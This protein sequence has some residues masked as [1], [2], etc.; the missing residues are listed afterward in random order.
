MNNNTVV[1]RYLFC[2]P[3]TAEPRV[4]AI[5]AQPHINAKEFRSDSSRFNHIVQSGSTRSIDNWMVLMEYLRIK[6]LTSTTRPEIFFPFQKSERHI[7][8]RIMPSFTSNNLAYKAPVFVPDPKNAK[9]KGDIT[10]N[11]VK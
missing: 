9:Q 11:D 1:S 8:H 7:R 5:A 3:F 4:T 6:I 10:E 2:L